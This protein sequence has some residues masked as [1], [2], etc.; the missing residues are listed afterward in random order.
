MESGRVESYSPLSSLHSYLVSWQQHE[1]KER[2]VPNVVGGRKSREPVACV[3]TP[4]QR[5]ILEEYVL[6]LE[7]QIEAIALRSHAESAV[8]SSRASPIEADPMAPVS[9]SAPPQGFPNTPVHG[10]PMTVQAPPTGVDQ[11]GNTPP[12]IAISRPLVVGDPPHEISPDVRNHLYRHPF[13]FNIQRLLYSLELP[14]SHPGAAHPALVDAVLLNGCL[15]AHE[16][17]QAHEPELV[18]RVR[19][20]LEHSLANA[21][22]LFDYVRASTLLSSYLYSRCRLIEGHYYNSSAMSLAVACG[23]SKII[24]IDLTLQPMQSLIE[25]PKDLAELGDRINLFWALSRIDRVATLLIGAVPR[26]PIHEEITTIWP[27]PPEYHNVDRALLQ[28]YGAVKALYDA[29]VQPAHDPVD[30]I[31]NL[32]SPRMKAFA[33]IYHVAA[34]YVQSKHHGGSD[35]LLDQT[36]AIGYSISHFVEFLSTFQFSQEQEPSI[37]GITT[38]QSTAS[39]ITH[40]VVVRINMIFR[41]TDPGSL[42]LQ[43]GSGDEILLAANEMAGLDDEYFPL[44][45]SVTITPI[46]LL[47]VREVGHQG[48]QEGAHLSADFEALLHALKQVQERTPPG[49]I[50]AFSI[51]ARIPNS[52]NCDG[53]DDAISKEP[54]AR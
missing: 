31:D 41:N 54:H 19:K 50:C 43:L 29:A 11:L 53:D 24:S 17:L 47:L 9:G 33:M 36:Q 39:A 18:F 15:Y 8:A 32:I 51:E 6:E 45:F 5:E 7:A 42:E 22:R 34:L 20:G 28:Q 35:S 2:L 48:E 52:R 10:G 30:D 14:P 49:H 3:Y 16:S 12:Q 40:G 27:C 38:S 26:E 13:E 23:L 25:P 37:A 1:K 21:D 44:V 4:N 46:Y